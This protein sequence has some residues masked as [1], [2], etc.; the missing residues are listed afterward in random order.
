LLEHKRVYWLLMFNMS[1]AMSSR[2]ELSLEKDKFNFALMLA[3]D[4]KKFPSLECI[5]LTP[6][7][8]LDVLGI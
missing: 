5:A 4:L 3:H 6:Q 7:Q 1:P 2:S 8:R